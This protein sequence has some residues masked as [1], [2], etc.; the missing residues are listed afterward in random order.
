MTSVVNPAHSSTAQAPAGGERLVDRLADFLARVSP[1]GEIRF[2]SNPGAEW[3]GLPAG[4]F[5]QGDTLFSI[6][7]AEDHGVL[8]ESLLQ[9]SRQGRQALTARLT[10]R[11]GSEARVTCRILNLVSVGDHVELLFAAWDAAGGETAHAGEAP[12]ESPPDPVTGL[13]TRPRLLGTLAELTRPGPA[14]APGFALLHLD[15]DGFQKVNDALGHAVGDRLLAEAAERLVS[16]LRAS[17]RVIR[18]GSDEFALIL[19]GCQALDAVLPVA[20]KV[21]SAMQRPYLLG[22][23]RL[24]LSASIGIALYPEH[25]QD[26]EQLFRCADIA[27]SAAK[28]EGRNRWSVYLAEGGEQSSRRVIL[29]EHM[30]DAIQNGEF[31]MHYQPICRADTRDMVG[32]EA[33]MRWHRP[34]EGFISPAEFIPLAERNG[35]IG[36]LGT[37]SLRAS[38]HQ[39]AQWNS[40]W[41]ARMRASVNISPAQFRQGDIVAKVREALEESG[42]PAECLSLE[43]TEG[44]LMHDPGETEALLNGLRALGLSIAVDDFGTGYSSLAYLKRFPLS[45]L[46]ID[47]SF[48]RD[49]DRDANDLAIV[50]A[51]LGLAKELGLKVVAE[52]VETEN[53]LAILAGKGCDLIQGYLLGRPISAEQLSDNVGSGEWRVAK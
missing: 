35:L 2:V 23:S 43:I 1:T 39:V 29:E 3:L 20:R 46:K 16:L 17:D 30:Y 34:G 36:F 18:S 42:L 51:I 32:V 41:G 4:F 10:R 9:A 15:L 52:G 53:Q 6:V 50:S 27:L 21:L 24:H 49:L 19:P 37:W 26:G 44:T 33:L 47:R 25:A 28:H 31:E 7:A 40:A 5:K 38:C 45:S 14:A 48:V 11:D 12:P 8:S 22:D 13:P